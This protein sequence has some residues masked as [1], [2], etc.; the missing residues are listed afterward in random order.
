MANDRWLN[1]FLLKTYSHAYTN[2]CE[3]TRAHTHTLIKGN[4]SRKRPWG[5]L[6]GA[7]IR[8]LGLKQPRKAEVH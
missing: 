4:E 7:Q 6:L 3:C 1:N 2:M 8:K 5:R